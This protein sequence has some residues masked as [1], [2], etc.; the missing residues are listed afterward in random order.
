MGRPFLE[1]AEI[2]RDHGAAWR[3]ANRG[4]VSLGQLK[5]GNCGVR[6]RRQSARD[7]VFAVRHRNRKESWARALNLWRF[8]R[9]LR[10]RWGGRPPTASVCQGSGV[11]IRYRGRRPPNRLPIFRQRNRRLGLIPCR[12]ATAEIFVPG[13]AASATM[14]CFSASPQRRRVSAII[15]YRREKPSPDIAPDLAPVVKNHH[16]QKLH[17][18]MFMKAD[19]VSTKA[20]T[21]EVSWRLVHLRVSCSLSRGAACM[22]DV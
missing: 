4:R 2:F 9:H 11:V 19:S 18:R 12:R 16:Q 1:V 13:G 6:C 15:V 3:Q 21:V 5:A 22:T 10:K 7:G 20:D 14:A 17:L 8:L